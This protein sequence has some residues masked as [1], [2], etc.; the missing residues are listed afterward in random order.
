LFFEIVENV[1]KSKTPARFEN[2]E[3]QVILPK[4]N[5]IFDQSSK[6]QIQ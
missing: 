1:D 6:I 5:K 4:V 3:L 2:V